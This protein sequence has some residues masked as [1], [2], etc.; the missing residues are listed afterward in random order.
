MKIN[1]S[2]AISTFHPSPS[3]EQ[4]YFE[5]VANA[6]DAGADKISLRIK[7]ESFDNP[8]SLELIVEDNG[9]GFINKNFN[10]FSRLL[11]VE[12]NDHKGLGRLVYL[13]YFEKINIESYYA[14][15][16]RIFTFDSNFNGE[17]EE[18]ENAEDKSGSTLYFS[19]Y[20]KEKIYSYDY[21]IPDKVKTS[22]IEQFFPLFFRK[23]EREEILNIEIS[24]TVD[25]PNYEYD[26][27]SCKINFN[28]NDLPN[29][30]KA[31]FQDLSVDFYANF[32]IHYSIDYNLEKDRSIYTAICI[33]NRALKYELI[34]IDSIPHGYQMRFLFISEYFEGKANSSR[35]RIDLPDEITER[36]LKAK[37]RA[38]IGRIIETNI[39]SVKTKNQEVSDKLN[40]QYPHLD[41]YFP[42]DSIGLIQKTSFLE[43][44]QKKFFSEQ[45]QILECDNL[46]DS[47]Y[48]KALELSSR[49]LAE[50]VIYRARI[51]SK[52]KEMSP[53]NS[54]EDLHKLIVPMRKTLKKE[55]HDDDIYNNNVWMLDDRFMSYNII[56][57]DEIMS[58]VIK[59]I[60][61][62]KVEDNSRP[63][64]TMVFSGNPNLEQKF[65]A[66]VVELK[67]KG[68]SLAK[69]EEVVSQLKQRARKLLKYFPNKIEKIW[70]Y[71]IT[72]IDNEFRISLKEQGFKE[73]FSHGQMFFNLQPI[74]VD[75]E[76]N[77]FMTDLF[78]MTYESLIMDAESRNDSFLKV[79]RCQIRKSLENNVLA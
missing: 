16:K 27:Y 11:E 67:K 12:S 71:G 4:I 23:K 77:P 48:E 74:I 72:D 32:D 42:S 14:S 62:D 66:V 5:A 63:D 2:K 69:N 58:K 31:T 38:E 30:E 55:V 7:I 29:L 73:L 26:F 35:Q 41:G 75:D 57:S 65:S 54:E 47:R 76:N 45:K 36:N 79:L 24:L 70:F 60:T 6:L 43:E 22:L 33:D 40:K 17:S 51:I 1:L 56:L 53:Q 78:V 64:I 13:S 19:K 44:A 34:L 15:K 28:L 68:L 20:I 50:Y 18:L 59:E 9:T 21:L 37:L 8:K 39:P 49:A 3:Y 61:L 52:L 25:C 46:D 10:K